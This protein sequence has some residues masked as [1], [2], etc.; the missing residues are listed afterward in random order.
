MAVARPEGPVTGARLGPVADDAVRRRGRRRRVRPGRR[1]SRRRLHRRDRR[2]PGTVP[3]PARGPGPAITSATHSQDVHR[4]LTV[5]GAAPAIVFGTSIGAVISLDL[6]ICHPGDVR[7]LVAHEPP[8]G[9]PQTGDGK[10]AVGFTGTRQ[11]TGDAQTALSQFGASLTPKHLLPLL[12][13]RQPG[14]QAT[15]RNSK[16]FI[17]NDAPAAQ[18]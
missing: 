16:F 13:H 1:P 12:S 5:L 2:P 11:Q 6:L 7:V 8:P 3:Q 10:P 9:P 14:D 17:T 15:A 4:I 18:R